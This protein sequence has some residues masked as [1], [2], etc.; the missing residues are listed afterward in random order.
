MKIVA[1]SREYSDQEGVALVTE[2]PVSPELFDEFQRRASV[3]GSF[4]FAARLRAGHLVVESATF[5][6]DLRGHL[7]RLLV[8]AHDSVSGA[9]ASR[10]AERDA[11]DRELALQSAAAGFELPIA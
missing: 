5:T 11:A 4:R 7:Q 9:A 2:P 10:Q 8:E 1:I 3:S 6:P